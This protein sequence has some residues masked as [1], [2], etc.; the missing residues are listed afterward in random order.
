MSRW[1]GRDVSLSKRVKAGIIIE[2]GRV[3]GAQPGWR[4]VCGMENFLRKTQRLERKDIIKFYQQ[5]QQ[6]QQQQQH[7]FV[8]TCGDGCYLD[9]LW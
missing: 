7:R 4:Q 3:W 5:Q 6:Q 2:S 1:K 8:S 9:L